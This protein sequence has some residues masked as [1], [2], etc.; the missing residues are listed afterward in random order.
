MSGFVS[1]HAWRGELAKEGGLGLSRRCMTLQ[2]NEDN[3]GRQRSAGIV[4][5]IRDVFCTYPLVLT[6][7]AFGVKVRMFSLRLVRSIRRTEQSLN[8]RSSRGVQEASD[9]AVVLSGGRHL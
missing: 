2:Y 5:M 4:P 7:T 3:A 9:S 1:A 6:V 8:C